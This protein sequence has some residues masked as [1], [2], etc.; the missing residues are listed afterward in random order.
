MVGGKKVACHVQL[1]TKLLCFKCVAIFTK[2]KSLLSYEFLRVMFKNKS[3][4]CNRQCNEKKILLYGKFVASEFHNNN[5]PS[6]HDKDDDDWCSDRRHSK[7][8]CK[9]KQLWFVTSS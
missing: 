2:K 1:S 5:S 4:V 7:V 6:L 8:P 9:M 3:A